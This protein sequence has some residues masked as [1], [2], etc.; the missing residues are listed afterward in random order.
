MQC[1][2]TAKLKQHE[3]LFLVP[4]EVE[5][6]SWHLRFMKR[7]I[8]IR[9]YNKSFFFGIP[10]GF[11]RATRQPAIHSHGGLLG[12][13]SSLDLQLI[14]DD[15]FSPSITIYVAWNATRLPIRQ[16]EMH[17]AEFM[18]GWKDG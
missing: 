15:F 8:R 1:F 11:G 6:L 9:C 2:D 18:K 7:A 16:Y 13:M 14:S 12:R 4:L 17:W 10:R 3:S 5:Y